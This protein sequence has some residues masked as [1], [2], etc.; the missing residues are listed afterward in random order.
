MDWGAIWLSL[1]LASAATSILFVAGIPLS[2]WLA[3]TRWRGRFLVEAVV[4][5]P[6]VLPP[7][8]LGF[9]L[10]VGLGPHGFVGKAWH[11]LFGTRL[12][13]SFPGILIGAVLFNLPFAIRPFTAAFSAMDRQLVEAAWC[14]GV[15]RFET[16]R[17][18]I[19]PLCWP[20][21]LAGVILT[22]AHTIGEFGVVLM[23]GG[24]IPSVTRTI[25]TS[26]YDD[27]QSLNYVSAGRTAATLLGF[28]FVVLCITQWLTNRSA[29]R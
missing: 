1:K 15:S 23:L 9:Y 24:N 10:L 26:L 6:L 14:L 2:Y 27:V 19:L 5:L 4:A 16:F 12:P 18:V 3:T 25:S 22:F 20:G 28:S 17:R 29:A 7:T 21:I 13:F 11:S 8:V